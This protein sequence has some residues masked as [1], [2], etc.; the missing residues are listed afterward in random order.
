MTK[1]SYDIAILGAGFGGS[2][3]AL[4]AHRVGL[5]TVLL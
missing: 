3:I 1:E 5:K 2:L 4:I